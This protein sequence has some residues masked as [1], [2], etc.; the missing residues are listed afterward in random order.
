MAALLAAVALASGL[1]LA[2][3]RS[4]GPPRPRAAVDAAAVMVASAPD[5][6]SVSAPG[7]ALEVSVRLVDVLGDAKVEAP[8]LEPA[9]QTLRAHWRRMKPAFVK[10]TPSAAKLLT[11]IALRTSAQET[12]ASMSL[13]A[14]KA[15]RPDARVWNMNEGSFDQRDAI[16]APIGATIAFD[17]DVPQG[18]L[19]V[20]STGT[21]N[22]TRATTVFTVSAVTPSGVRREICVSRVAPAQARRG[23]ELRCDLAELAGSKVALS[24]A[25]TEEAP[26]AADRDVPPPPKPRPQKPQ[27]PADGADAGAPAVES[28]SRPGAPVAA[29]W[30][31]PMILARRAPRLAKN[32]LFI[33][34]DALRPDVIASM[35]DDAD[36]ARARQARLP[37]LE[38]RLPKI[39]GI[40]PNI[41]GLAARGVRFTSAY[42]AACWTRPGTLA[43]LAGARSS[44]LGID[45]LQWA[46]RPPQ[47]GRF[48]A[49]DPPLLPLLAR[50]RGA[51]ANAFVNN[52][53]MVGYAAV[54]VDMGFDRVDDHRYRTRDTLEITRAATDW[55]RA[56]REA[57]FFAF[58]NYNSPHEPYEP[59]PEHLARVPAPPDGPKDPAV[60][61]YMAE[62]AKDDDAIGVLL[63]T[64]DELG[65]TESTVVVLTADHG[66]TLSSAHTGTSLL[67]RMPIRY[68]HAVSNFEETTRV[69]III[70]APGLLPAGAVV[71]D[72]VRTTDI[73]PTV[74]ELVGAE[75]PPRMSGRSLTGLA[76]GNAE[77]P[78]VVVSEGRGSRAILYGRYRLVVR[79]GKVRTTI[80]AGQSRT[81]A[82]E[83][84][85]LEDDPGERQD[86][87][88][89]RPDLVKEMKARLTA[90]LA[91]VAPAGAPDA[92]A[93]PV[94]HAPMVRLRF[95]G[96]GRTRR[97]SGTLVVGTKEA[98]PKSVRATP[99]ELGQETVRVDGAR[100]EV[101]FVTSPDAIVGLDLA[102]DPP[103]SPVA[104]DL[105]LDD[106]AW[107]AA[108]AHGGP[109]GF[110]APSLVKGV[111]DDASR[112]AAAGLTLPYLDPH[113]DEGLFVLR[114]SG[115]EP[116][117][118]PEANDEGAEELSRLLREWGYA[119]GNAADAGP[120]K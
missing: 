76:R 110:A 89:T 68:H 28:L 96:A 58:V 98:P 109:W 64:L 103:G 57:R 37:P 74:T 104:W 10:A 5:A 102:V 15:W 95:G 79:E 19:L 34:V 9:L 17:V 60:R 118:A 117:A 63:R 99:V 72:R 24:L 7:E 44:E 27:P 31:T 87:A 101:S 39:E 120:P 97:V 54:G 65:L 12:Q 18:A 67:D 2:R 84:F 29:L 52:Y 30:G 71:R 6:G 53:F 61:M 45:T 91:G 14:G 49:G 25:V 81:V 78:R 90:E 113:R 50:R 106:A 92:P 42:S 66:E 114:N 85:D 93:T 1:V 116:E 107:P 75:T 119:H 26:T 77:P 86:I 115:A 80:R 112:T 69:P 73:A 48:Y 111:V 11:T 4:P 20:A 16:V 8:G 82:E 40:T 32:V 13:G 21:V 43:M 47:P 88:P 22:A 62:A 38:A 23:N 56:N 70:A 41:D 3:D 108:L 33:V 36:D 83:L 51:I 59:P 35:H 94:E 105:Y 100:V 55:L 46:V